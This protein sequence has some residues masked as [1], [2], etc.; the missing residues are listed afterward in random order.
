MKHGSMWLHLVTRRPHLLNLDKPRCTNHRGS[1]PPG[2]PTPKPTQSEGGM[3]QPPW[4]ACDVA[5][6]SLHAH[7]IIHRHATATGAT[8]LHRPGKKNSKVDGVGRAQGVK[9]LAPCLPSPIPNICTARSG[10][11]LNNGDKCVSKALWNASNTSIT[12]TI[13]GCAGTL[14]TTTYLQAL[15]KESSTSCCR[16]TTPT[17]G[18]LLVR[19][20]LA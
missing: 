9:C 18:V 11:R 2:Q 1:N 14:N 12:W 20:F 13:P 8:Q 4:A 17:V 16:P 19:V 15:L 7:L 5:S 10:V 3:Q 6:T